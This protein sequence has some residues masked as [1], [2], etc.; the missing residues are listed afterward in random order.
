MP[1]SLTQV[2]AACQKLWPQSLAD[3]WDRPGLVSGVSGASIS[4]VLLTIDVTKQV[5]E[6]AISGGFQLV[7][8]HH[9]YLLKAVSTVAEDTAKGEVLSLAIKNEISIFAAHTNADVTATGVSA[10]LAKA[11]GLTSAKP[12]VPIKGVIGHG[13]IGKL[14]KPQS[15]INF[16]RSIAKVLPATAGGIRVAGDPNGKISLVAL[17]GGAGD[18]FISAAIEQSADVYVTSDLRHHPTQDA[19]EQSRVSEHPMALIDISHWAAES[20]WLHV[21]AKELAKALPGVK[22]EVSDLR[23]DSWDFAV[24]Q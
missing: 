21:A 24:T 17:C 5:I 15:L 10:T 4:K 18:S 16:A 12:L 22:F 9:P 19:I 13:R 1:K 14:A 23:T 6:D 2:L 11:F 20:L 8:A 3:E 7:I